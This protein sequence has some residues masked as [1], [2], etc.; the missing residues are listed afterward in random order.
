M[1]NTRVL[2]SRLSYYFKKRFKSTSSGI[3]LR[4]ADLSLRAL[5]SLTAILEGVDVRSEAFARILRGESDFKTKAFRF[6]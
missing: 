1:T 5:S 6:M 3:T 4:N 2:N